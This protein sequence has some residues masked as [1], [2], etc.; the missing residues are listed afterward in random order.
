MNE[1]IRDV[2]TPYFDKIIRKIELLDDRICNIDIRINK[3]EQNINYKIDFINEKHEQ[4]EKK[5]NTLP[6]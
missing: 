6:D 3:L 1:L 5:T 2:I 4:H